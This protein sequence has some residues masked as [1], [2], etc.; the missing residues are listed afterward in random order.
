MIFLKK[1]QIALIV[2]SCF[3]TARPQTC[4]SMHEAE[5]T[6]RSEGHR[7]SPIKV[8]LLSSPEPT[9]SKLPGSGPFFLTI[10]GVNSHTKS[11]LLALET[12]ELPLRKGMLQSLIFIG[13]GSKERRPLGMSFVSPLIPLSE[14]VTLGFMGVA[15]SEKGLEDLAKLLTDSSLSMSLDSLYLELTSHEVDE[16]LIAVFKALEKSP[17]SR[18][19]IAG[20]QC[21]DETLDVLT[22]VL[23]RTQIS[24][25]DIHGIHTGSAFDRLIASLPETKVRKLWY[26]GRDTSPRLKTWQKVSDINK[27]VRVK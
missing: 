18:L 26:S 8:N 14:L 1:L 6:E 5:E 7:L 16:G 27:A 21:Q 24:W 10:K 9:F 19:S 13:E 25:L 12:K 4:H 20:L 3:V 23:P 22:E 11:L 17:I 2:L 15:L